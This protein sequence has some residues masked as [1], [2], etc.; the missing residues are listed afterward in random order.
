M[1]SIRWFLIT[2]LALVFSLSIQINA[3]AA[4]GKPIELRWSTF[5]PATHPLFPM[6][7]NWGSEIEK[8]TGGQVK[9]TYF[10][11]GT[12]LKGNIGIVDLA[13]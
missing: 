9:F 4:G 7:E 6:S 13:R 10:P 11:G 5:F 1:K 8:M 3:Y 12:L 2:S